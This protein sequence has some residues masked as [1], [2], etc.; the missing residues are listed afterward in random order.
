M[1]SMKFDIVSPERNMASGDATLVVLPGVEGDLGAGP[2][3]A[4]FL[5]TL[6]PGVVTAR[7]ESGE[8]NY[9]V[10]GGF[11]EISPD[12]VTV[13]ADEVEPLEGLDPS[14]LD[15]RI[16]EVE[17]LVG[18]GDPDTMELN[19]LKLASLRQLKEQHGK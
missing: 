10:Y 16:A 7:L 5:T 1:A 18:A 13:L 9:V 17:Q 11:A 6:R 8:Q 2:G 15:A 19:A 3:H 14:A 12:A 4:L